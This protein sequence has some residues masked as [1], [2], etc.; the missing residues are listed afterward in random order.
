MQKDFKGT[1]AMVGTAICW[2]LGG[3]FIKLIDWNPITIA[4]ARSVIAAIF[5]FAVLRRPRITLSKNQLIA[6]IAYSLTM[7]LFIYANKHTT[8][9]NAILLQYGA[10]VYV[11]LLSGILLKERPLPEQIGA[12]FA[13]L[14]GMGFF[15]ADSLSLGHL[16]GDIAAV[17]AGLTFAV[18]IL[19]MRR[20]K[21]G[22]PLE[23][24]LLGHI[25]TACIGIGVSLFLPRPHFSL[26]ATGAALGL[27]I[28]QI[29]FAALLFSYAITRI[30]AIQGS[31][32]AII[33]PALNPVWVYLVTGEAPG[34]RAILGGTII[35]AAVAV[36][37]VI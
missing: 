5:I 21:D 25:L 15:F 11:M 36:S 29:G 26:Q 14:I 9:A 12:L 10:P 2:S 33:E 34:A 20:Q 13:I 17:L 31:L 8:S 23:S 4:G 28:V 24:L 19:F 35:I 32:I 7:L 27:G 6:A 1:L 22:S 16:N 37:S 18:H 30:S 3:L